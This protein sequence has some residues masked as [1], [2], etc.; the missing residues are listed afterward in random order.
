MKL[1]EFFLH[2]LR[3][4]HPGPRISFV[5]LTL[6]VCANAADVFAEKP[7]AP[8]YTMA[9]WAS[10]KGLLPGDV[11]TIAQDLEGYLWLG[12]P[13]GLVRFDGSRFEPWTLQSGASTLP[14]SEVAALIGSVKGGLWIGYSG[15]AGVA[16]MHKGRATRHLAGIEDE[17]DR[18]VPAWEA[19]SLA[20]ELATE[21]SSRR[22]ALGL[23]E[24]LLERMVFSGRH[25]PLLKSVTVAA[26]DSLSKIAARFGTTVDALR[27]L[28]DLKAEVIQPGQR[29]RVLP[30]KV[31]VHVD[32]ADFR[33]WLR[34]DGRVLLERRVGLGRDNGTPVGVFTVAVRQKDP[35]WFRP[36]EPP[37][38][39]G[40]SRNVLGSRW[41]G[42]KATEELSG[43]LDCDTVVLPEDLN[44]EIGDPEITDESDTEATASV[45]VT[46]A[47]TDIEL[48]LGMVNQDGKWLVNE[49]NGVG[50]GDLPSELP[51]IPSLTIPSITIPSFTVPSS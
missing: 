5:L 28:N 15:G 4:P 51:S 35:S 11:F 41:L 22:Q 20:Y 43:S 31:T 34:V 16:H 37:I 50:G 45:P 17:P 39:A 21:P 47:G 29:L 14:A 2:R 19:L 42:F 10:E 44:V 30:G 32:K 26:G 46:A 49:F 6:L 36:G 27:R 9:V 13:D 7:P 24:P 8:N 48:I 38:P 40:D 1:R 3:V 23:L 12:T 18:A 33:L 25:S